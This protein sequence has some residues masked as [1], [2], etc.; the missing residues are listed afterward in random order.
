MLLSVG[1]GNLRSIESCMYTTV[2]T[3]IERNHS[4]LNNIHYNQSKQLYFNGCRFINSTV[5]VRSRL[6]WKIQLQIHYYRLRSRADNMFGSICPSLCPPVSDHSQGQRLRSRSH[7]STGVEW[8]IVVLGFA[9][10]SKKSGEIQI[11]YTVHS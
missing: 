9:N 8:S 11:R 3:C 4:P 5:T 2:G 10:Y 7:F 1:K 6:H